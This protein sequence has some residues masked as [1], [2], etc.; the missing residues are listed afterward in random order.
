MIRAII[1]ALLITGLNPAIA[2]DNN[3]FSGATSI[4]VGMTL[5]SI[6]PKANNR[7]HNL[8]VLPAESITHRDTTI[9]S[10]TTNEGAKINTAQ[11]HPFRMRCTIDGRPMADWRGNAI[12]FKGDV[13][14][15]TVPPDAAGPMMVLLWAG[16][17]RCR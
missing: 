11:S 10:S 13:G 14:W 6:T 4:S 5:D 9:I 2:Q 12:R 17:A 3:P 7:R 16:G 15:A 8:R 1:A